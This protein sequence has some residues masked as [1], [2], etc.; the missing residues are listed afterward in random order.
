MGFLYK[1]LKYIILFANLLFALTQGVFL[2]A[3]FAYDFSCPSFLFHLFLTL[4][5]LWAGINGFM[6]QSKAERDRE[7][8]LIALE[9]MWDELTLTVRENRM[10]DGL[11]NWKRDGF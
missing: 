6:K 10:G 8:L 5:F 1:S 3:C 7:R 11:V 4:F 9:G 2:Y